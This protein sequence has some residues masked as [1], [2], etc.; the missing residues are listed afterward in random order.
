MNSSKT[1]SIMRV[2]QKLEFR[3]KFNCLKR[4]GERERERG[5]IWEIADGRITVKF[6]VFFD[7]KATGYVY[8]VIF[9]KKNFFFHIFKKMI[10]SGYKYIY[11]YTYAHFGQRNDENALTCNRQEKRKIILKIF[12]CN[13]N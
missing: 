11:M 3:G 4:E 12:N 10:A 9:R 8:L 1:N 7:F 2:K 5:G 13:E 6:M